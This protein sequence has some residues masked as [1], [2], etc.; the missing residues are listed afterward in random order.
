MRKE[1]IDYLAA[2]GS[3][4]VEELKDIR[5]EHYILTAL[6]SDTSNP[7]TMNEVIDKLKS[8]SEIH[9]KYIE[10]E[11][12]TRMINNLFLATQEQHKALI[13]ALKKENGK[14]L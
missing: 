1:I 9:E 4:A 7:E 11:V 10:L 3:Y 5:S 13:E 8:T 12:R 6:S 14:G 2:I